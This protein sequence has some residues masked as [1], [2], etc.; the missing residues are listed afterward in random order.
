MYV[1][2]VR[3]LFN[4]FYQFIDQYDLFVVEKIE[5]AYLL[6]NLSLFIIDSKLF[7]RSRRF[8]KI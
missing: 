7:A 3:V 1:T 8:N 6:R 2:K 5:I 4:I